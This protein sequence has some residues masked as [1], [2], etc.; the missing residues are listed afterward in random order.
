LASCE[1]RLI[2]FVRSEFQESPLENWEL[3]WHF[4]SSHLLTPYSAD[5]NPVTASAG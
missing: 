5:T 2:Q 4:L 1:G 3:Q